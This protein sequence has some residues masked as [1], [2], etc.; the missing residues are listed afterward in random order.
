LGGNHDGV[1]SMSGDEAVVVFEDVPSDDN[2]SSDD[3]DNDETSTQCSD[4]A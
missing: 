1:S 4:S 3:D 2:D